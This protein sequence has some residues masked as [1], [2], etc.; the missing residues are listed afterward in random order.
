MIFVAG[1]TGN[2]GSEI[3][4]RLAAAGE[5]VRVLTRD[6]A[7]AKHLEASGVEITRGDVRDGREVMRAVGGSTT[8]ISAIQGFGGP[9]AVGTN[10]VDRDGNATLIRAA[11]NAGVEHFVLMSV[12]GARGD[13]PMTLF[14]AKAA[15]ESELLASGLSWTIVR[16]TSYMETWI[17]IIG[18]PLAKKGK[19]VVFGRGETPINFVSLRDVAGVIER[20]LSDP[21]AR[22]AAFDVAGPKDLTFSQFADALILARGGAGKVSHVPRPMMRLASTLLKPFNPILADQI[23][24]GLVMDTQSFA[25]TSRP[26]LGAVPS[27]RLEAL[28]SERR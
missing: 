21:A 27:T 17:D 25:A 13:H 26:V 3:V 11:K 28:L 5:K 20:A 18:G 23:R 24:A 12:L 14:R 19:A 7:R 1:G 9:N 10:A 6:P 8:V 2:L 15:A 4:R 16:P 22:G